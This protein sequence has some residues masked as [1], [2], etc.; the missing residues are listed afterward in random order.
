MWVHARGASCRVDDADSSP[1]SIPSENGMANVES[2]V[3]PVLHTPYDYDEG[4]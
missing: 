4:F 1:E 2:I 3:F